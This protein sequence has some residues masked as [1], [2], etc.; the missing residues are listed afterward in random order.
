MLKQNWRPRLLGDDSWIRQPEHRERA[1]VES[2]DWKTG[3]A[4]AIPSDELLTA[5]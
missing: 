2:M 1:V 3:D 4:V 5:E